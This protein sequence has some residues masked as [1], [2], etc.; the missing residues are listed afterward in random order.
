M[1]KKQLNINIKEYVCYKDGMRWDKT[2]LQSDENGRKIRNIFDEAYKERRGGF[3]YGIVYA[4]HLK[5]IAEVLIKDLKIIS[6]IQ[7]LRKV[8]EKLRN[9]AAHTMI[10]ITDE[11]VKIE[12]GFTSAQI[13]KKLKEM[14]RYA[15]VNIKAEQ[16][17]DYEKMNSI[18][19]KR[20][21][22]QNSEYT[23]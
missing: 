17:N 18:I 2:K 22:S 8:E 23:F 4:N 3:R 13:I 21:E 14:C 10:S 15:G 12:S 7:D 6:L 11:K 16:W 19:I 20:I 1:L 5:E 9:P